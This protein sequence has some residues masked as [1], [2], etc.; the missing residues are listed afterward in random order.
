MCGIAGL[1]GSL[2]AAG[3]GSSVVQAMTAT[4]QHRG[5]DGEG[6][7]IADGRPVAL[8]QR[9]LAIID[10]SAG[11]RQPRVG[12][13][14]Q[15]AITYNGEL[16]NYRELRA[17]LATAGWVFD[18][19]SDTEVMLAGIVVWGMETMLRRANGMFGLAFWDARSSDLWLARDR[20]G[21]KPVYWT[22]LAGSLA[23]ASELKAL[24]VVPG[25]DATLDHD[26]LG[27]YFRYGG[28][29]PPATV[30]GGTHALEPGCALRFAVEG[31]RVS[32]PAELR[33][34]DP[35]EA[36]A[37]ARR[38][39]FAGSFEDAVDALESVLGRSVAQRMVADVPLGAFLSG[40]ID[41]SAIVSLMVRANTSTVRTFTIGF[42]DERYNEAP[43]AR[44][45]A[46]HLGVDHTEFT[47]EAKQALEIVPRLADMYDEPFADSS[48]IPTY[49]VSSLAR[50]HVTVA[51]SGDGGDELF[52]GYNRYR[53]AGNIWER[54]GWVPPAV[55][56]AVARGVRVVPPER[57][58]ALASPLISRSSKLRG[59]HGSAGDRLHKAAGLLAHRDSAA[60]YDGFL[61]YWPERVVLGSSEYRYPMPDE[62]SGSF[63]ERMM[64]GD[65]AGY[66]PNDILVKTD[67]ASMAASLET[68]VPMLDPD[69]YA[70]AWSMPTKWKVANGEGKVVLRELL[71]RHVPRSLF[72]RPKAGF[73]IPLE[74]WLRGPLREFADDLLQPDRLRRQGLLDADLVAARWAEHRSGRRNWQHLLWAALMFELWYERWMTADVA[75]PAR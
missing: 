16:Y 41:S 13:G 57:L 45:V 39:P 68:R 43:A 52:G 66:L 32:A 48:Q 40:G 33:Y 69:V 2:V 29:V 50:E 38:T 73:G 10:L 1:V 30:Y 27:G 19:E 62:G 8:G 56:Q 21:E 3:S 36:A 11:G 24:R 31:D 60:L 15:C 53:L 55:R 20:F 51:L 34:W 75:Q 61:T 12:L 58:D 67:R 28:F 71:S 37:A 74:S 47:V 63:V 25:F 5:P 44:A 59:L 18:S 64:L 70:L 26:A 54:V 42:A 23:F 6:L 7:W 9:R 35:I 17:E 22:T 65:T 49:V 72:E 14:G 46:R 4:M